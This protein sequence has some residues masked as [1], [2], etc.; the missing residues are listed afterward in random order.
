MES[1]T[2][3]V[4]RERTITAAR[5]LVDEK[6]S[7]C[8]RQAVEEKAWEYKTK[9]PQVSENLERNQHCGA[10]LRHHLSRSTDLAQPDG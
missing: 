2:T 5:G 8:L 6:L 10:G 1:T 3:R 4:I 9:E 7:T